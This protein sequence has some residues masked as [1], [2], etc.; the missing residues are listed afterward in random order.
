MI[1]ELMLVGAGGFA[2]HKWLKSQEKAIAKNAETYKRTPQAPVKTIQRTPINASSEYNR[3]VSNFE[4][5]FSKPK[6]KSKRPL[7]TTGDIELSISLDIKNDGDYKKAEDK[8]DELNDYLN[9]VDNETRPILEDAIDQL[10][11]AM[12]NYR[13]G[14]DDDKKT[15]SADSEDYDYD[16]FEGTIHDANDI[17]H[18]RTKARI[19]YK[20]KNG[21]ETFRDVD[22]NGIGTSGNGKAIYGYC[23]LRNANR[24]FIIKNIKEYIDLDTGEVIEYVLPHL[25]KKYQASP[26]KSLDDFLSQYLDILEVLFYVGKADTQLKKDERAIICDAVRIIAKDDR[27]DDSMI[28]R[29][30]DQMYLCSERTF[31]IKIGKMIEY[32]LELKQEIFNT[33]SAIINTQKT[34]H[35]AEQTALDYTKKKFEF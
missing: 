12:D 4:T 24:T 32:S 34:I 27:I 14:F 23:H 18:I 11:N 3:A 15:D 7:K 2:V 13:Y 6:T 19:V 22:V 5:N 25:E 21:N 30:M 35:P 17:L 29:I 10:E 26:H 9:I 28:N 1:F 31:K 8:L 20:D 16:P 33:M